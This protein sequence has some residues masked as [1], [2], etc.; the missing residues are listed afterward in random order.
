M[1]PETERTLRNLNVIK[2]HRRIDDKLSDE[3]DRCVELRFDRLFKEDVNEFEA[4][5]LDTRAQMVKRRREQLTFALEAFVA[6]TSRHGKDR[7][8]G[9]DE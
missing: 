4:K 6:A 8:V 3:V 5:E 9:D 7:A 2:Y 1:K